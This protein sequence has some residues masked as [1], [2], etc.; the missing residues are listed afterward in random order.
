MRVK[1]STAL[2]VA[3]LLATTMS[4]VAG[5]MV[6]PGG[7]L[8]PLAGPLLVGASG[9]VTGTISIGNIYPLC[10]GYPTTAPAP[11]YYNQIE[12]VITP[13]PSSDL[14]L[15]VPVNWVLLNG[16]TIH[17]T[18]R[19]GLNPGAYSLTLTSCL[20]Q[21]NSFGCSELPRLVTV[22]PNTWTPV[23]ISVTT[24]IY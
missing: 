7:Y 15:T 16:C 13:S 5:L 9:G 3:A 17:G 24:G 2:I 1:R 10:T 21:P 12:V 23:E 8:A 20:S 11:P 22:E 6:A 19:V 14:P 4:T 18:F